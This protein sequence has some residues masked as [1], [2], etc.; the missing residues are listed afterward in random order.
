MN[1][2]RLFQQHHLTG[3]HEIHGNHTVEVNPARHLAS[4]VV[5]T[6]PELL[7][8]SEPWATRSGK[9]KHSADVKEQINTTKGILLRMR[10]SLF[11]FFR[12]AYLTSYLINAT[13]APAKNTTLKKINTPQ[14]GMTAARRSLT[15]SSL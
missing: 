2:G 15:G 11:Q 5:L 4:S 10:T 12:A 8:L 6:V 1:I 9:L 13:N 3:L 7:V 14:Y